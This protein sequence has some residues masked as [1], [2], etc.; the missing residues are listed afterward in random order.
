MRR[1][2]ER[3]SFR[4]S[5]RLSK[6]NGS[7]HSKCC[8]DDAVK[9]GDAED[10]KPNGLTGLYAGKDKEDGT[11][12]KVGVGWC[13]LEDG[14]IAEMWFVADEADAKGIK[15]AEDIA[16]S[17]PRKAARNRLRPKRN[18]SPRLVNSAPASASP[19]FSGVVA[20]QVDVNVNRFHPSHLQVMPSGWP[21]SRSVLRPA[22]IPGQP[23]E[24]FSITSLPTEIHRA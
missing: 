6:W 16:N 5:A 24:T 14:K 23:F 12:I 8:A 10:W 2:A 1:R 7:R 9:L 19:T 15:Q 11:P 22:M 4:I 3:F 20:M 13:A 18:K 21:V 17:P